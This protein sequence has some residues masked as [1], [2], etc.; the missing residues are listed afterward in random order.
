MGLPARDGTGTLLA[1]VRA[2]DGAGITP[3]DV[4]LQRPS[5]DD[6]FLAVT[7]DVPTEVPA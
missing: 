1:A 5:L 2:L 3:E 4:T 7:G 6:V